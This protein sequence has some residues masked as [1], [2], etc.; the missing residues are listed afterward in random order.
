MA[1][2]IRNRNTADN[3]QVYMRRFNGKDT[4]KEVHLC[5]FETVIRATDNGKRTFVFM[6]RIGRVSGRSIEVIF[7]CIILPCFQEE[8][9]TLLEKDIKMGG[10]I[11]T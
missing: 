4:S 2:L 10:K 9:S 5:L 7:A 11:R 8:N 6:G 1:V 3:T